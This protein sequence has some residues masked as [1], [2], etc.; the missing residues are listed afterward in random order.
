MRNRKTLGWLM[1]ALLGVLVSPCATGVVAQDV[2]L[3]LDEDGRLVNFERDI[4]PIFR[5]RCLEC[6]EGDD[7]KAGFAMDDR[8]VVLSY[9]EPEDPELSTMYIDYMVAMD[10][11]MLMPPKSHDGPLSPG[12]L[13][14]IRQWIV[15]GADWPEAVT[16]TSAESEAKVPVAPAAEIS[17]V[18]RVWAFQGYFHPA[19][20][21]F[22]VALFTVGALFV[23]LGIVWRKVGTQIPLACLLL[24]SASAVVASLMG[25]AF[26]AERGHPGVAL[27]FESEV[28]AHRWSGVIV[29]VLAVILSLIALAAVRKSS[30]SL[31]FVWKGGLVA[32]AA[33]VGLVGHQGG[34]MTYPGLY[35]RA[36]ER[37]MPAAQ[38]EADG[39]TGEQ[40]QDSAE[41]T[42]ESGEADDAAEEAADDADTSSDAE[43][44]ASEEPA[45]DESS[46]ESGA[47][48]S[49][50]GESAADE[51]AAATSKG[52]VAAE[53]GAS[54]SQEVEKLETGDEGD[55][56]ASGAGAAAA[57]VKPLEEDG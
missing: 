36:F 43:A 52:P 55:A 11:S 38:A 57:T 49:G 18:A 39:T 2:I 12:E 42:G 54:V 19:T 53:A 8:E 45:G 22:P 23:V 3:P 25:W 47:G 30:K 28:N 13:A 46:N 16:L 17:Q 34:E 7:A 32:L 48:E 4:A 6:H 24:G 5:T 20:V 9:V 51:A 10:E 31:A 37:L 41:V 21:H 26:A 29:S 1:L 40:T 44:E 56:S 50:A 27:S 35:D 15:E 33:M 14:L